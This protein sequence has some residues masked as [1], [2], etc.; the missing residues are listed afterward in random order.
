MLSAF[1]LGGLVGRKLQMIITDG[2]CRASGGGF[3]APT[4]ARCI[5]AAGS[6]KCA[7]FWKSFASAT[8]RRSRQAIYN[9]E[10]RRQAQQAFR[11]FQKNWL[12]DYPSLVRQLER[13]LPERLN[14]FAFPRHLWRKVRTTNVIECLWKSEDELGPRS[15]S[16][17]SKAWTESLTRCF[18]RFNLEWR[19][20]TLHVF[21][22]AWLTSPLIKTTD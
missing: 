16:L 1:Q 7:T 3:G 11:Q 21:T 2:L 9:A 17:I 5:S 10:N 4:R 18:H 14:F 8:M 12:A 19:N 22:E 15:A 13:D 6:T 20:R